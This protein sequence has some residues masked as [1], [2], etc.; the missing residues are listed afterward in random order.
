MATNRRPPTAAEATTMAP[1]F[2]VVDEHVARNPIARA[3]A[4]AALSAA[5]LDFQLHP[6]LLPDGAKVQA[7]GMASAKVLAVAIR[8]CE[9]TGQA[10]SPECRVMRGGLEVC[11]QLSERGWRWRTAD[12]NA[13]DIA[14]QRAL[15]V[16]RGAA[17][18]VQTQAWQFVTALER[19]PKAAGSTPKFSPLPHPT[20]DTEGLPHHAT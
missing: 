7:D 8:V 15:E 13:L 2:K 19:S 18:V 3:M 17:A 16:Y 10:Q 5:V 9:V 4:R 20:T 6:H 11:V 1:D 12:V 14:L